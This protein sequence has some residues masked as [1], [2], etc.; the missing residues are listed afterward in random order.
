M[1]VSVHTAYLWIILLFLTVCV[2]VTELKIVSIKIPEL[3]ILLLLPV[4]FIVSRSINKYLVYFFTYFLLL[5]VITFIKNL[6]QE[7]YYPIDSLSLLKKPYFI[8]ISRLVELICCLAFAMIVYKGLLYLQKKGFNIYRVLQ[9][10]LQV[11]MY[12]AMIFI[13]VLFLIKLGFISI[14]NSIIFYKNNARLRGFF[15]EGGP[16]GLFYAFLFGLAFIVPGKNI[17]L[18]I[19]FIVTIA[20]AQ[21]KAGILMAT[22]WIFYMIY[23]K[24]KKDY[25]TTP[26]ILGGLALVFIFV[27]L[28]VARNYYSDINSIKQEVAERPNDSALVMGRISG[29]F[30]TNN[31]VADNPLLGVGLGNY[32]LVRNNPDY[33]TFFPYVNKWDLPGSGA[34]ATM[35]AENG[36]LGIFLLFGILYLFY[37]KLKEKTREA[38]KIL[39]LFILPCLLGVQ[40]YFIYIWFIIGLG[41]FISSQDEYFVK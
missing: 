34:F 27:G 9:K 37:R 23:L 10:F 31:M 12:L 40:L 3:L 16:F 25:A 7:F 38:D 17:L 26:I 30:I 29:F 19:V 8:T 4:L 21:S 33:R 1:R 28:Y 15:V 5:V 11:N 41:I 22:A 6:F 24:F 32:S 20:L 35:L 2:Q 36:F 39:L 18:K 13:A 14:E